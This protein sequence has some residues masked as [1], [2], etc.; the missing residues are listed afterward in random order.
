[1][2]GHRGCARSLAYLVYTL[3]ARRACTQVQRQPLQP[4]NGGQD[5]TPCKSAD[6][7]VL[8]RL[9]EELSAAH[10]HVEQLHQQSVAA[11]EN[12]AELSSQLQSAQQ[13]AEV[14]RQQLDEVQQAGAAAQQQQFVLQQQVEALHAQHA[15]TAAQW[16]AAE[17]A[18]CEALASAQA[19]VEHLHR[20][21]RPEQQL[22]HGFA[23]AAASAQQLRCPRSPSDSFHAPR[24]AVSS[25]GLVRHPS[26]VAERLWQ[27]VPLPLPQAT[28][29]WECVHDNPAFVDREQW[30]QGDV[31]APG[32]EAGVEAVLSAA[33]ACGAAAPGA[34]GSAA[35]AGDD[36]AA[37]GDWYS[38]RI[39][40][41]EDT[42]GSLR[43]QL[44]AQEDTLSELRKQQ[45]PPLHDSAASRADWAAALDLGGD[46]YGEARGTAAGAPG[47]HAP[48]QPASMLADA[49]VQTDGGM[50]SA[51]AGASELL[52]QAARREMQRLK[53]VNQQLLDSHAAGMACGLF[54]QL[55]CGL[56]ACWAAPVAM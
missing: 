4:L 29:S 3:R 42:V 15:T 1:M 2:C 19:E 12:A 13:K 47:E 43:R 30:P 36:A 48:L 37:A 33:N 6:Q 21:Q 32:Q 38:G 40:D 56:R 39:A 55:G 20:Q 28:G 44:R 8:R 27:A 22:P 54:L 10:Q 18:L 11:T 46:G 52:L 34:V 35:A 7:R 14:M 50:G 17:A 41:L 25:P 45:G 9:Q 16:A 23:E 49:A 24:S 5:A 51:A 26:L 53:D 31:P